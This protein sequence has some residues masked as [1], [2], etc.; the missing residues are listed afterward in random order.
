[1]KIIS[2]RREPISRFI[3]NM[4]YV[5]IKKEFGGRFSNVTPHTGPVIMATAARYGSAITPYFFLRLRFPDDRMKVC[6]FSE[7]KEIEEFLFYH[8]VE[9]NPKKK[10]FIDKTEKGNYFVRLRHSDHEFTYYWILPK[11]VYVD[12]DSKCIL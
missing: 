4:F 12:P 3:L 10:A 1:M 5:E 6:L 11:K 8:F 9:G 7:T 2:Y